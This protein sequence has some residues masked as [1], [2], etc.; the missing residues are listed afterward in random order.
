M[1]VRSGSPRGGGAG[2]SEGMV[3]EGG[4]RMVKRALLKSYA[5]LA[6]SRMASAMT[7]NELAE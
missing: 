7:M 3:R 6:S 5:M 1:G 2:E 4:L